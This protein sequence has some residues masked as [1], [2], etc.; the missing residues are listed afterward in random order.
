MVTATATDTSNNTSEFAV[1][2]Y[3]STCPGGVVTTTADAGFASLRECINLANSNPG[4]TISFNIPGPGNQSAGADSWWR[5]S[6]TSALPTVT[7]A[8]TIIDA[9]TQTVNQ[10]DTNSQGPEIELDG[11]G[12]GAS[13]R[14]LTI[15]GGNSTVRGLVINRFT[16][17]GIYLVSFGG[18]IIEGNYIGTDATGTTDLGNS[19]SGVYVYLSTGNTIGG[20]SPGTGNLISGND[21]N[22]IEWTT[23][24]GV[25]LYRADG[26]SVI[27]NYIGTDRTGTVAIGNEREGVGISNC[28][29]NTVGGSGAGEENLISGNSGVGVWIG[30]GG[31][32]GNQVLGNLIGTQVDGTSPLGN[33]SHGVAIS[34]TATNNIIGG[35][36]T[37][38]GNVIAYSTGD[39]VWIDGSTTDFNLIS[40]NA[41][42]ENG[43]LGI[44]LES[45]GVGATGG[46]NNNK[47]APV[48]TG[49]APSGSDIA[50]IATA[51]SG[52]TV[53]FF[54]VD[55]AA[56]PAV[57]VD[58]SGSGEGYLYLGSCVDNGACSGP[59]ISAV[60]DADVATGSVQAV[61]LSTGVGFGETVTATA[62]DTSSNTSEFATNFFLSPCPGGVVITT[63]DSGFASLRE[64]INYANSNP[65][66]TISFDI[67]GPG[68]Q[69]SGAD[70]WW[71]ITLSTALPSITAD[72]TTIDATTQTANRGD[73]NTQGPEVEING[74]GI[75]DHGLTII[76]TNNTVRGFLITRFSSSSYHAINISGAGA[77]GNVIAG[78]YIGTN[79]AGT[80]ADA[81]TRNG[82]GIRIA[83]GAQNNTIGGTAANDRNLLSGNTYRG[84][85]ITGTGTDANQ[86][87]GNYIGTTVEG[88][89][90]LPNGMGIFINSGA[91]NNTIGGPNPGEGNLISGNT[92]EGI[93][94]EATGTE[95]NIVQGNYI[96]T[97]I[98]GTSPLGN[99]DGIGIHSAST[100]SVIGGGATGAGNIISGN[101]RFG[102]WIS[103]SG[104]DSH[105]FQ[106]NLIGTDA[107]GTGNL[108]NGSHGIYISSN[109]NS[110]IIGGSA[111]GEGNVIAYSG[112][113]GI[114]ILSPMF[115][116]DYN[117]ISGNSIF[118]NAGL[119]IDLDPD[120]VGATG[121]ANMNKA[122]PVIG[123]ISHSGSDFT[124]VAT[125]TSGDTIEFFRVNNAAVPAVTADPGGSG[126]GYL[127]LGTCVDNGACSGPHIS[128]VADAD[129]AAGSVQAVLLSSGLS[130]GDVVTATA[131]DTSN[132]TSEFG[133]N[134]TVS[135][136]YN[137]EGFVYEDVDGDGDILDDGVA[138]GSVVVH[139][140]RDG[141]DGVPDGSD[142]IFVTTEGTDAGG[143]FQFGDRLNGTYWIVVD[144]KTVR[145]G[146]ATTDVWAEQTYGSVGSVTQIGASYSFSPDRRTALR[147]QTQRGFRR[148]VDACRRRARYPSYRI[149]CR[150]HR[151]R[152]RL[153]LQ[154]GYQHPRRGRRSVER[155]HDPG[156]AAAISA[157]RQRQCGH[158]VVQVCHPDHR[159][160]LQ[161]GNEQLPD[162]S[163]HS[164]ALYQWGCAP[165]RCHTGRLRR[166][167]DHRPRRQ[168][169]RSG[170]PRV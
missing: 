165:R 153:Q 37:G 70:S 73:T 35:S 154:R 109:S 142:D 40:G 51:G 36:A 2:A 77:T 125:V 151:H 31:T 49:I 44:D 104:T 76:S 139:L 16:L 141:G 113:D 30:G 75:S 55:N 78:N 162:P 14:G 117:R 169:G 42:F 132:N 83:D 88:S 134:A 81:S 157:E 12:A 168:P 26:N 22:A 152:F 21:Y 167:A 138:T 107:A 115:G 67:P 144:S 119:G 27:G 66:T 161:C 34:N 18:N 164:F 25:M 94:I 74:N 89:A 147:R 131:T 124:A 50:I 128:P 86:V 45:D 170:R 103:G 140:Y 92:N 9:T 65:G 95:G 62:T 143:Q 43:G 39:G 61:L 48:I 160:E 150:R 96:G 100:S 11:G 112:G 8:G 1:N 126:E 159:L 17:D 135:A 158:E 64:C 3:T 71:R 108:G 118:E 106:G 38:E 136:T 137:L 123:S 149:R 80:A 91:K 146:A 46:A 57:T 114:A 20:S 85:T 4:T 101:S 79:F 6:P 84:I 148:R 98:L 127:Y 60:A 97:D 63:A 120:G 69:S 28:I 15:A 47:A 163:R 90:A 156:I 130:I 93:R 59:H 10:G 99:T 122:A 13:V 23:G 72:G 68:N 116:G 32:T 24:R 53:E 105:I 54:R 129:A 41:I 102:V 33:G 29:N 58:P 133:Q 111:A 87:L 121:G 145:P 19:G 82:Y 7:A 155:P 52:D 110:N 166:H 56:A 5:I